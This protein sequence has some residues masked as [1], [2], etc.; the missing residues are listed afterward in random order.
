MN[1]KEFMEELVEGLD[2][3]AN[4]LEEIVRFKRGGQ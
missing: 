3:I 1:E 2:R 4:A